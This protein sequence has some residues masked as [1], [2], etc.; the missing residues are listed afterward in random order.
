L[1][2]PPAPANQALPVVL[3]LHGSGIDARVMTYFCGLD[4]LAVRAGFAVVYPNGTGR[5]SRNLSWNAGR[6][7]GFAQREGV[8]DVAFIDAL[9]DE[10][11]RHLPVDARRIYVT[12]MS[13]GGMMA[14]RLAA[15][16]SHRIA[17]IAPVAGGMELDECQPAEAVSVCHFHGTADEYAPFEGGLGKK[18]LTK[19]RFH[20]VA[21]GIAC[22]VKANDCSP[23]PVIEQLPAAVDDGTSVT[24]AVYSGGR[25]SSEVVLYTIENMGHTWPGKETVFPHLGR[26]SHNLD[27]NQVMWEFFQR[28]ER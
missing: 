14:Y 19:V 3:A 27:A 7:C 28:H 21:H 13:A 8:D 4:E 26:T 9:L 22:W 18:S 6:C 10:L 23:V 1:Y 12:G 2:R 20:P 5:T 25:E 24:R 11:P 16:L 17:A 15:E